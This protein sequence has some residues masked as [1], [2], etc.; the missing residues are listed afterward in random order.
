MIATFLKFTG[1]SKLGGLLAAIGVGLG[2]LFVFGA[3]KKREGRKQ[4]RAKTQEKTIEN[5]QKAKHG[6]DSLSDPD[7]RKRL[8]DKYGSK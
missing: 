6:V 4:E 7:R 1:L 8:R 3:S 5:V 2:A